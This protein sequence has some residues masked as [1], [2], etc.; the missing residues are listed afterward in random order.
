[1]ASSLRRILPINRHPDI[2]DL[3]A[4][5]WCM[6]SSANSGNVH[7]HRNGQHQALIQNVP[8][9]LIRLLSAGFCFNNQKQFACCRQCQPA[10]ATSSTINYATIFNIL[11]F[12]LLRKNSINYQC[13]K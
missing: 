4:V 12:I 7:P 13:K 6:G 2:L 3:L 10:I 8:L 9:H 11:S 5:G 1:M